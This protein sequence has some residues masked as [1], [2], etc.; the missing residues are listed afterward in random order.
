MKGTMIASCPGSCGELFQCVV[1]G[2]EFLMSYGI[3]KKS[4]VVIGPQAGQVG[5]VLRPKMLQVMNELTDQ[6]D[7]DF[8]FQTDISIGKGYSSSTADMLSILGAYSAYKH[9][10]V[11]VSL[12]TSLCSKIEPSDSVGFSDWTVMNPLNGEIKWQT[13]WK[14]KLYVYILEPDQIVDTT[15]FIRMTESPL[16]PA[17]Q[18][19]TLLTYFKIA[20]DKQ[21]VEL[22]GAVATRSAL[23]NNKRL[24]KPYLEDIIEITT[25]LGLL[26]VNVAHSGSIVG[27]LMTQDQ[28]CHLYKLEERLSQHPLASYYSIRNLSRIIYD[29]LEVK[30]VEGIFG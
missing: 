29:G 8:S 3:E 6:I 21:N 17:E 23:L 20:C 4:Q 10:E 1:D 5:E 26:G 18:S 14:P 16:Y 12:L 2:R 9:K 28:L 25:E 15:S 24:P 13:R 30:K 22:L 27:I 11:S 19:K 7:F